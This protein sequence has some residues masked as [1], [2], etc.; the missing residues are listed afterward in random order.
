MPILGSLAVGD[1]VEIEFDA[2]PTN[3]GTTVVNSGY[4]VDPGTPRPVVTPRV[5][6]VAP[7]GAG[8]QRTVVGPA[9]MLVIDIDVP[10]AGRGVLEV[11]VNGAPRDSKRVDGD[12]EF[13]YIV[14]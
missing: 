5:M 12:I 7:G 13:G 4:D 8:V 10:D 1:N 2:D 3:V 14:G 6:F 9:V 11:R